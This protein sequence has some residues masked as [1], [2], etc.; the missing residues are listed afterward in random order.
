MIDQVSDV[1][2]HSLIRNHQIR[3]SPA[4]VLKLDHPVSKHLQNDDKAIEIQ[5]KGNIF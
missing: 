1:A 3:Y 4:S 2:F 5:L